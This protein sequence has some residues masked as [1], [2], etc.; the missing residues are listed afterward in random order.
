MVSLTDSTAIGKRSFLDCYRRARLAGLTSQNIRSGWKATGLWP[1]TMAKPLLSPLL[2]EN[3]NK[4]AIELVN[5][6]TPG[7]GSPT[8]SIQAAFHGSTIVWSTPRKAQD[9][10]RSLS[11][12]SHRVQPITTR[13]Q[14]FH[15]VQ[16]AID[17]KDVQLA[18]SLEKIKSLEAQVEAG[19]ARKRKKVK[20][21]PNSKFADIEAIYKAQVEAGEAENGPDESSESDIPSETG[22]CI[23]VGSVVRVE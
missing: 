11:V 3:S 20:T 10:R 16:K 1:V 4:P 14:L 13:R 18:T 8:A 15:K 23:I 19:K 7:M 17:E 2:L 6:S 22:S 9:L 21:S 12:L 5:P